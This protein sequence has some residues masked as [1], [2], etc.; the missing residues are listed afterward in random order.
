M[1]FPGHAMLFSHLITGCF[2]LEPRQRIFSLGKIETS[3]TWYDF[4]PSCTLQIKKKHKLKCQPGNLSGSKDY[5]DICVQL[6]WEVHLYMLT[7]CYKR[8]PYHQQRELCKDCVQWDYQLRQKQ[9]EQCEQMPLLP[10]ASSSYSTHKHIF[11]HDIRY[12]TL[13]YIW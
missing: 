7:I 3:W 6:T 4:R 8:C 12:S 1:T 9:L 10:R 13:I 5:M 2:R 11:S